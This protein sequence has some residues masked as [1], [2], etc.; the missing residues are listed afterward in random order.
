MNRAVLW[1]FVLL[2][3]I[4]Q[5]AA[6]AAPDADLWPLWQASDETSAATIDHSPWQRF[7][8]RYVETD[9]SAN[10]NL[11]RYVAVAEIDRL[12]LRNY[13]ETLQSLDPRR[14]PRRVQLAYWINLYN[15]ATV[16]LVLRNP[17]KRSILRMGEGLF[18]IG[19][20]DD[21]ILEV[22]GVALTLNDI[23]HRI[24]RPIWQDRRVHFAVNCASVSCPNLSKIAYTAENVDRLLSENE[25][26]YINDPRGVR[27][28]SRG[29]LEVS[30]IFDWYLRDF[31]AT[32]ET[33]LEYLAQHA[34]APLGD[35]LRNYDRRIRYEYDWSLNEAR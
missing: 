12:A 5:A 19:P 13:L 23:E 26:A 18:S 16:D 30:R 21:A 22:G 33:L 17:D 15:A 1:L 28:D 11:V 31:A 3:V 32:P 6:T 9:A 29:R 14:Y 8:D 27:F 24:L 7:L 35:R 4:W 10:V 2:A 20:W 25:N 34:D